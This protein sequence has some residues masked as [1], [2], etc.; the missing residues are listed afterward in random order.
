MSCSLKQSGGT[1]SNDLIN[2]A[3]E[4]DEDARAGQLNKVSSSKRYWA[5]TNLLFGDVAGEAQDNH[6][7]LDISKWFK[8]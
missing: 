6:Y 7:H 3:S 2:V 1:T 4:I 5:T 8:D